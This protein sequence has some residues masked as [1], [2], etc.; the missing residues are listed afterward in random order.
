MMD[1]FPERDLDPPEYLT[2]AECGIDFYLADYEEL[3]DDRP[4]LCCDC[5]TFDG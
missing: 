1:D 5:T 3:E 4:V 2:C